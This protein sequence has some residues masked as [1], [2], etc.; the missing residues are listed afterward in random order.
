MFLRSS[1]IWLPVLFHD[2]NSEVLY[3]KTGGYR[4]SYSG[5]YSRIYS[6]LCG[7]T[8]NIDK[9]QRKD[10]D[11]QVG[12]GLVMDMDDNIHL[13]I[14]YNQYL[15][16]PGFSRF[17]LY[18]SHAFT[19]ED[20][21]KNIYRKFTKDFLFQSVEAGASLMVVKDI[22][23]LYTTPIEIPEFNSFEEQLE[24]LNNAGKILYD[25]E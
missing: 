13:L 25:G 15:Y 11:L 22:N 2:I 21:F 16:T 18:L 5:T 17:R 24:F 10:T 6:R 23:S 4:Y 7:S 8:F 1:V 12:R 14:T 3:W 9:Y 20:R 19:T